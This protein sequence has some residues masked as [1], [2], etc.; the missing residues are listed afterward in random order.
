MERVEFFFSIFSLSTLSLFCHVW[1]DFCAL[2][3]I[4][5]GNNN[6]TAHYMHTQL[7]LSLS[8]LMQK[9]SVLKMQ[10]FCMKIKFFCI[11]V[12]FGGRVLPLFI[13]FRLSDRTSARIYDKLMSRTLLPLLTTS[14][15]HM[16]L[17]KSISRV[18]FYFQLDSSPELYYAAALVSGFIYH[19]HKFTGS[20]AL[21]I[22]FFISFENTTE[23]Y[24]YR[25]ENR[26]EEKSF[27]KK[28]NKNFKKQTK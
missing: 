13:K 1:C 10:S 5:C 28:I 4:A 26:D 17:I 15:G 14:L 21:V 6:F 7:S 18:Q 19:P 24:L 12:Y 27:S 25:F 22:S 11:Q 20:R 2:Y 16:I 23:Q 8:L 9:I 3:V